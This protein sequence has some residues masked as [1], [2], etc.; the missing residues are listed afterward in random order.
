MSQQGQSALSLSPIEPGCS[1]STIHPGCRRNTTDNHLWKENRHTDFPLWSNMAVVREQGFYWSY[2]T[3]TPMRVLFFHTQ[4]SINWLQFFCRTG[5]R[6]CAMPLCVSVFVSQLN[7]FFNLCQEWVSVRPQL[8]KT[9]QQ[10]FHYPRSDLLYTCVCVWTRA[11]QTYISCSLFL[12]G[13]SRW[14]IW[15]F[16]LDQYIPILKSLRNDFVNCLLSFLNI[17]LLIFMPPSNSD[18][19]RLKRTSEIF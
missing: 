18:A 19:S 17:M 4:H 1:L 13:C 15:T 6:G 5:H 14:S 12:A 3:T 9:P 11:P 16:I 8:H 2:L 10:Q 7:G